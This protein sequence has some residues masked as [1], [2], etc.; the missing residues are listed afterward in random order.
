MDQKPSFVQRL[1][2]HPLIG[3]KHDSED[4]S[5]LHK[6]PIAFFPWIGIEVDGLSPSCYGPEGAF[7][8]FLCL[9][10]VLMTPYDILSHLLRTKIEFNEN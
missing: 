9:S 7:I 6:L 4:S 3:D 1:K 2:T 5:L 10:M 8:A